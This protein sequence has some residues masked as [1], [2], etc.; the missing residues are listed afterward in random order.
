[1]GMVGYKTVLTLHIR[2]NVIQKYDYCKRILLQL[3]KD[4]ANN[5]RGARTILRYQY[6]DYQKHSETRIEGV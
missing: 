4:T 5:H 3:K 6:A 1:M 2:I